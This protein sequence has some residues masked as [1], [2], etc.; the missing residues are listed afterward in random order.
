MYF[1]FVIRKP[2]SPDIFNSLSPYYNQYLVNCTIQELLQVTCWWLSTYIAK[3]NGMKKY[4][5]NSLACF[6]RCVPSYYRKPENFN[7]RKK[8]NLVPHLTTDIRL[9]W[10]GL[11]CGWVTN[12]EFIW[13]ILLQGSSLVKLSWIG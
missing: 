1:L 5:M 3:R 9:C 11:N 4:K 13:S 2:F 6:A 12:L 10:M 8:E 7:H